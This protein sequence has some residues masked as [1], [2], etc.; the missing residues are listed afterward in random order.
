MLRIESKIDPSLYLKTIHVKQGLH[1]YDFRSL[2]VIVA[3]T[4]CRC[5]LFNV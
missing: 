3:L 5:E 2:F 1:Q 4:I